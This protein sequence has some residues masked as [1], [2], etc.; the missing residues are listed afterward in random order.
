MPSH[1]RSTG[2]AT[3][4][5]AA[6]AGLSGAPAAADLLVTTTADQLD[7]DCAT[8]TV[9]A[10]GPELSL[11]ESICIANAEAGGETIVLAAASYALGLGDAFESGNAEGDLDVHDDLRIEGAGRTATSVDAAGIDRALEVHAGTVELLDLTITGGQLP[12]VPAFGEIFLYDGATISQVT[13]APTGNSSNPS[14]DGGAIA[15]N[16]NADLTGGNADGSFEVFFYDGATIT[17]VTSATT[18]NSFVPSLDDGAVAFSS[19][20]VTAGNPDASFEI[21]LATCVAS[22]SV[23]EIPTLSELAL[24]AFALLL[25]ASAAFHLRRRPSPAL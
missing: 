22:Q 16:S 20:A 11:R 6:L 10:A 8:L 24:V 17:Q 13:S 25:A 23:T 12:P 5:A 9:A 21:F 3:L 14:L 15:F 18:G 2:R 19:N 7:G 4:L 1:Q